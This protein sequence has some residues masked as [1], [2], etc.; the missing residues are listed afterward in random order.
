MKRILE[1]RPKFHFFKMEIFG[2]LLQTLIKVVNQHN[3]IIFGNFL[4]QT[5]VALII[6]QINLKHKI[7]III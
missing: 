2:L 3:L 6:N 4:T 7:H 1:V 5:I